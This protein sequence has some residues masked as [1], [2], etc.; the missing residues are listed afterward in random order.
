ML[1]L[2]FCKP[3][4]SY[5]VSLVPLLPCTCLYLQSPGIKVWPWA[6]RKKKLFLVDSLRDCSWKT[7]E[8]LQ[9]RDVATAERA[10]VILHCT[11]VTVISNWHSLGS[12][13]CMIVR[14][15]LIW[16]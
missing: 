13:H 10:V 7:V 4:L 5:W 12:R 9:N 15:V 8:V 2:A 6:K 3:D 1:P 16:Q 14:D 11:D